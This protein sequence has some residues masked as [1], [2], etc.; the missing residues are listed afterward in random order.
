MVDAP[1]GRLAFVG[2]LARSGISQTRHAVGEVA[3]HLPRAERD[4]IVLLLATALV[5]PVMSLVGLSPVLGFLFA[6]TLIGPA[7]LC[8]V[9]DVA[10]TTKLAELGVVFF[11][12]EMGLEVRGR[13][14]GPAVG[15]ACALSRRSR[16]AYA[17]ALVPCP[18]RPDPY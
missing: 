8:W 9:S 14:H 6:G 7:C 4:T 10:T 2:D 1:A 3:D 5:N 17:R 11:L 18:P 15:R 16:P 13:P 12:F